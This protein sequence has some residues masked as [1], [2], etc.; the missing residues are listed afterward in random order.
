MCCHILKHV[1]VILIQPNVVPFLV[2]GCSILVSFIIVFLVPIL[3]YTI[4]LCFTRFYNTRAGLIDKGME[5]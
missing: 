1:D 3:Y 5:T 2:I 4:F